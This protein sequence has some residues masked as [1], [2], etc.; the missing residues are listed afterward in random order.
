MDSPANCWVTDSRNMA[1]DSGVFG[2]RLGRLAK[3][4][5]WVAFRIDFAG[6]HSL[7]GIKV[8]RSDLGFGPGLVNVG[9]LI[10]LGDSEKFTF[11]EVR[12]DGA[13]L[14]PFPGRGESPGV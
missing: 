4:G 8:L 10:Y 9:G 13:P 3:T 1:K 6:L 2:G 11:L 14:V 12:V 5:D 7:E